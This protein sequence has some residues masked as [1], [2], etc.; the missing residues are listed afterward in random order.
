MG[1]RFGARARAGS[2][3]RPCAPG[4]RLQDQG[5]VGARARARAKPP[6]QPSGVLEDV[7]AVLG[8][9]YLVVGLG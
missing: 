2:S 8:D 1:L 5:W 4:P 7:D 3:T 6:V 9:K